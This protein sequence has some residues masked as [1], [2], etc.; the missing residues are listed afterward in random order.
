MYSA[1]TGASHLAGQ[2]DPVAY[3]IVRTETQRMMDERTGSKINSGPRQPVTEKKQTD[4]QAF[5]F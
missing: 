2:L 3:N 1:E 4:G 5:Y